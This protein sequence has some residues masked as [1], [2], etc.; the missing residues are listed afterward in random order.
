M[1]ETEVNCT[2]AVLDLN[3]DVTSYRIPFYQRRYAWTEENCEILLD[4]ILAR[5]QDPCKTGHY[6]GIVTLC[7]TAP[8]EYDVVDGQQRLTTLSL[9][10]KILSECPGVDADGVFKE[11]CIHPGAGLPLVSFQDPWDQM[12]YRQIMLGNH[13]NVSQRDNRI[14]LNY[15]FLKKKI[16]EFGKDSFGNLR[17][18]SRIQ[19]AKVVLPKNLVPERIFRRMNGSRLELSFMD[20]VRNFLLMQTKDSAMEA[21]TYKEIRDMKD[22]EWPFRLI[23]RANNCGKSGDTR[24]LYREFVSAYGKLRDRWRVCRG[25]EMTPVTF[26]TE[27][28]K[29]WIYRAA[30]YSEKAREDMPGLRLG[31]EDRYGCQFMRIAIAA[32]IESEAVLTAADQLI[33]DMI[34]DARYF[35]IRYQLHR[36]NVDPKWFLPCCWGSSGE[37]SHWSYEEVERQALEDLTS[38]VNGGLRESLKNW[39]L[40]DPLTRATRTAERVGLSKEDTLLHLEPESAELKLDEI[41][42]RVWTQPN[43]KIQQWKSIAETHHP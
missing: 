38:K 33:R 10:F 28:N 7:E 25:S 2:R 16:E 36:S 15:Y 4:D 12:A 1:N 11:F 37:A 3:R 21:E 26:L 41:I 29:R 9:I 24:V 39:L 8:G 43:R 23:A 32:E 6:L 5:L 42:D 17:A 20:L 19:I 31:D 35:L 30:R 40:Q 22:Q 14:L 13:C 27:L 34:M 18:W